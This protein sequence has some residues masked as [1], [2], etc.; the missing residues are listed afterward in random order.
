MLVAEHSKDP[1]N[2]GICVCQTQTW[3]T[4]KSLQ[5][6]NHRIAPSFIMSPSN[7]NDRHSIFIDTF[8]DNSGPTAD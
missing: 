4:D 7:K 1:N 3:N 8:L 2:N 6:V 5:F